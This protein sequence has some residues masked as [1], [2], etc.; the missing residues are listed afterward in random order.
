MV[1]SQH[2]NMSLGL[3][4]HLRCPEE[5]QKTKSWRLRKGRWILIADSKVKKQAQ[6][7][8]RAR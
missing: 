8:Q 5:P 1:L 4:V 2:T 6:Q 3:E 7:P